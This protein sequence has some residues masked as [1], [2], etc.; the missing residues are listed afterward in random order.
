[1]LLKLRLKQL[2]NNS[3]HNI[4]SLKKTAA[5]EAA[6][7]FSCFAFLLQRCNEIIFAG[8]IKYHI[9]VDPELIAE[10]VGDFKLFR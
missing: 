10:F 2:L 8:K 7:F 3:Q 9:R 6:V 1:M 4:S 5:I